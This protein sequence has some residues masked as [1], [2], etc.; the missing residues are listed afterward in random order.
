MSESE[1]IAVQE[2]QEPVVILQDIYQSAEEQVVYEQVA[3]EQENIKLE[4]V[5]SDTKTIPELVFI[6]PYRDREKY[7]KIFADAMKTV[8]LNSPPYKIFYVNQTDARGFNRGAMKNIGFLA[9]KQMYPDDY[10]K[11][12]LV[13][14]DIDTFPSKNTVLDYKTTRGV[15]K[16]FYGFTYTLGGIV[17]INASDFEKLN[18]FPNFW[19]WGYEDNMIQNRA[20]QHAIVIDRSV[21]YR[22]HD[23]SIVHLIDTSIRTVNRTEF[24]RFV[25]NTRE[26][27]DSIRDLKYRVNEE[28]GFIDV[29]EFN[30]TV[31]ELVD[32]RSE[33]DLRNGPAPFKPKS[34]RNPKMRM[35]FSGRAD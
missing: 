27:I 13:F 20:I 16:H 11:I 34:R 29:L 5:T 8:L 10:Q 1:F 32:T 6:V 9:V 22:I 28:T 7:Q 14:N 33:Y 2:E 15:I 17:S 23:P 26:G 21:F 25:Q 12:T 31:A 24:D 30:T 18:G 35:N 3:E 19:S 4:I